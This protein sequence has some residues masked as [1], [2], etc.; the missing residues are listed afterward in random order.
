M[1][2][3]PYCTQTDK[4][5]SN[6]ALKEEMREWVFRNGIYY[7]E[8]MRKQE[9]YCLIEAHRPKEKKK[10]FKNEAIL[11]VFGHTPI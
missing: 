9:L 1:D 4:A 8:K 5:P 2:N 10:T 6:Y 11:K 7:D 3:A